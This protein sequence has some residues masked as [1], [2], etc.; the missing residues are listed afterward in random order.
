MYGAVA[1]VATGDTQRYERD[2][3]ALSRRYRLITASLLWAAANPV[4]RPRIVPAA[5][6][7]PWLFRAAVGQLAL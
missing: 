7:L 4:L 3:L 2:Y 5:Q 6:R 1:R